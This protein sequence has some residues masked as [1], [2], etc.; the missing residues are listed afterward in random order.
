[1]TTRLRPQ[2]PP[3]R[4]PFGRTVVLSAAAA[5]CWTLACRGGDA[6][7]APGKGGT[8]TTQPA[9]TRPAKDWKTPTFPARK[10]ERAAMV[11]TLR[12]YGISDPA[13]L[14]AMGSVGRHEFVPADYSGLAYADTPL[15]IGHDQTIS[16]PYIVAEMTQQLKLTKDSK[17]LEVGTGSGYQ[18]AVLAELTPHVYTIEI[19]KPLA[20]SARKRLK[21]LGYD[22]V[23][24]RHGDGYLGWPDAAPFDA[25][26]VPAAAGKVPP[27]LI[28]QLKPGGRMVIPVGMQ[29]GVQKLMLIEKQKDGKLRT[30]SLMS[31]RFVPLTREKDKPA[32]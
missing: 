22:V 11:R 19:L 28:R 6:T 5:L 9:T 1:M 24:V 18:A 12:R 23:Q 25:I 8:P 21:R 20:E 29:G 17:V 27:P 10:D 4:R 32:K 26:I 2:H 15:P 13:T 16:Q 30:R 7:P 14:D 31:V 3:R